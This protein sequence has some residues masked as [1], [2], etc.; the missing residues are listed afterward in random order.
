M[1]AQEA[2]LAAQISVDAHF[3]SLWVSIHSLTHALLPVHW[4]FLTVCSCFLTF[5][6]S[7]A[8][9]LA[10][11]GLL[12]PI[13]RS[14]SQS[15][16]SLKSHCLPPVTHFPTSRSPRSLLHAV[17]MIPHLAPYIHQLPTTKRYQSLAYTQ[18]G[19]CALHLTAFSRPSLDEEPSRF[20]SRNTR[21][22]IP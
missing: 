8:K 7:H 22:Y 4:H 5:L 1:D 15:T 2:R 10:S 18:L 19:A 3:L 17:F 14:L 20:T 6:L 13:Q 9:Q 12:S 21:T 11:A 16:F